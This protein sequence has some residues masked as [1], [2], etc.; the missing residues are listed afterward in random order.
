[1]SSDWGNLIASAGQGDK[2]AWD[3]MVER[4]RPLLRQLADRQLDGR[5]RH[6]VEPSDIVQESLADAWKARE[7]FKGRSRAELVAWFQAILEHNVQDAVRE[8]IEADK[9]S[10]RQER[11][12]DELRSSGAA[13]PDVF[14]SAELSPGTRLAR[15]ESIARLMQFLDDL[16]PRQR[17]ALRMRYIEH[18]TLH[19][20]AAHLNCKTNAAAQLIARGLSNLR[21]SHEQVQSPSN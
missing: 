17:E 11:S 8:H 4:L 21:R 3:L 16:P 15:R 9:R 2:Q 20:I 13:R 7:G 18:R 12:L 19:E 14:I 5:L 10:V 6:R 1:M